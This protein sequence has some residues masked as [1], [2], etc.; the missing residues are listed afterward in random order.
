VI[1]EQ[2]VMGPP[3]TVEVSTVAGAR[4]SGHAGLARIDVDGGRVSAIGASE[5]PDRYPALVVDGAAVVPAFVDPHVH[6]DKAFLAGRLEASEL[7]RGTLADALASTSLL[8]GGFT[9]QDIR[10]RAVRAL[11]E[12]VD[13]GVTAAR[14]HVEV[15]PVL[16]LLGVE[17]HLELRDEWADVIELQL[18]AFPQGGILADVRMLEL[19]DESMRVGCDVVGGCPYADDDQ[20][21]HIKRIFDIAERWGAPVDF[22]I[23]FSDDP[24]QHAVDV[25]VEQTAARGLAGRVTVG[26]LTSLAAVS[27]AEASSRVDALARGGVHVVVLPTTDIHLG[28]QSGELQRPGALAPV[29]LLTRRGVNVAIGSNNLRNAFGP[30]GRADPLGLAWL[31]GVASHLGTG[32]EQRLLLDMVTENAARVLGHR[33]WDLRAGSPA[34]MTVLDTADPARAVVSGPRVLGALHRG[35]FRAFT[36]PRRAPRVQ[37]A[38]VLPDP[39]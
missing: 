12:L 28:G 3:A 22:H 21:A 19:L 18:V 6:L 23:D 5:E 35:R 2:A 32:A 29:V 15:E 39:T 38:L 24:L 30:L 37:Q 8:R 4:L 1:G 16:G 7:P 34:D 25:V 14:V 36:S 13:N 9:R 26:H 27:V 17:V 11:V 10:S 33:R 20:V 31:V